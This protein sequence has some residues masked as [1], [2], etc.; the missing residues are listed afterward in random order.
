[1][2]VEDEEGTLKKTIGYLKKLDKAEENEE[3]AEVEI[4]EEDLDVEGGGETQA[5]GGRRWILFKCHRE[6]RKNSGTC[7]IKTLQMFGLLQNA[8]SRGGKAPTTTK[9]VGLCEVPA[10]GTG[11]QANTRRTEGGLVCGEAP[12]GSEEGTRRIRG[13]SARKPSESED[14][15]R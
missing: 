15:R 14:L 13:R 1:M 5:E 10:G 8:M 3:I 9:W 7:M 12:S 2:E 6:E 11:H 4:N